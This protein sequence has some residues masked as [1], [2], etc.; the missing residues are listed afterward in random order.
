MKSGK[1]TSKEEMMN[2]MYADDID[3]GPVSDNI[4]S[5]QIVHLK[6]QVKPFGLS[7]RGRSGYVLVTIN[8]AEVAA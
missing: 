4:V 7:V 2:T 8:A 5:V 1:I 3:G 6:N